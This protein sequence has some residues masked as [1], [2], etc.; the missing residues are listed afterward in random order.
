MAVVEPWQANRQWPRLFRTRCCPGQLEHRVWRL[1]L[2][3]PKGLYMRRCTSSRSILCQSGHTQAS[4]PISRVQS[5]RQSDVSSWSTAVATAL[6]FKGQS[7]NPRLL[8]IPTRFS[9]HLSL[10]K[11]KSRE[12]Q[13]SFLVHMRRCDVGSFGS[14]HFSRETRRWKIV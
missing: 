4:I 3:Q 5:E 13:D 14:T 12:R 10:T 2:A 9:E 6:I 7:T 1:T 8:D 11:L